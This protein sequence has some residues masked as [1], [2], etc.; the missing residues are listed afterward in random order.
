MALTKD[1]IA[2][3]LTE[4]LGIDKPVAKQLVESFFDEICLILKEERELKVSKFGNFVVRD[5]PQRPGR[6]PKTGE[7][8]P[9]SARS[10]V[11][12][13]SGQRLKKEVENPSLE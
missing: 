5:K 3:N 2:E 13:K 10:V 8:I 6:N 12:F 9:I 4:K 1:N 7:G 11:T